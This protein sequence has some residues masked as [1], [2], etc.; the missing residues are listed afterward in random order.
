[1]KTIEKL[2]KNI[3]DVLSDHIT[4]SDISYEELS[5]VIDSDSLLDSMKILRDLMFRKWLILF[6]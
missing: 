5:V 6:N 3:N 1:M 4:S 2:K